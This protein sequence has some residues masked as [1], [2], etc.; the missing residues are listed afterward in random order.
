MS[1]QQKRDWIIAH[2]QLKYPDRKKGDTKRQYTFNYWMERDDKEKVAVCRQFFLATLDIGK[3]LIHYT[4]MNSLGCGVAKPDHRGRHRPGNK[5]RDALENDVIRYIS[6]L[7]AVPSHYC[8]SQSSRKYLPV[9]LRNL[10]FV[11]NLY[12][13]DSKEKNKSFVSE[14]VFRRIFHTKFNIGFHLPK[15]DKCTK[16]EK[17]KN[18]PEEARTEAIKQLQIEHEA[19]KNAT[20]RKHIEDQQLPRKDESVVCCSFDLQAVLATPRSDSVL[21]FYSRK[22]VMYNF[23]VYESFSRKGNCYIWGEADGHRGSNEIATCLHSYLLS[24]DS[25]GT[26][27]KHV[28]MYCDCCGGQNRNRVV[29]SM[30]KY[31]LDVTQ[32]ITDIT[33]NFLLPGHTYMPADSMHAT[34]ERFTKRRVVWAPSQWPQMIALART[35][36]GPYDVTLLKHTDFL[37]WRSLEKLL[38]RQLKDTKQNIVKWLSVRSI[39]LTKGHDVATVRYSFI[40]S[41]EIYVPLVQSRRRTRRGQVAQPMPAYCSRLPISAAKFK[42]LEQL[43]VK[44]IIPAEY[45]SEFL[46]L[47]VDADIPDCLPETDEE[48]NQ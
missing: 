43:C 13:K 5:T 9:E 12:K 8:R 21:L 46:S 11:Y 30:L 40:G 3:R 16:C 15:K 34:I 35:N 39:H 20:L 38:P 6:A 14:A 28:M 44:G 26:D 1:Y 23:T 24:L 33:L 41:D 47:P 2:T 42:D 22:Y 31:T 25:R 37:Q 18:T 4:V 36:P 10:S 29:L 17:F 27:I 45:R 19:E 7:P 32:N 48:D